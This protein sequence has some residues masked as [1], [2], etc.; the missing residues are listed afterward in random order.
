VVLVLFG[1]T[2]SYGQWRLSQNFTTGSPI[3]V[4]AVQ[5]AIRREFR[6]RPEYQQLGIAEYIALTQKAAAARPDLVFWP[7]Y[8]ISFYLEEASPE[9]AM[10]MRASHRLG[11]DLILGGP[12]YAFAGDATVYHNSIYLLRDARIAGRYDKMRLLPVAEDDVLGSFAG[13]DSYAPG[14]GAD[15]LRAGPASVGAFLCFEAMYPEV[16]RR[17]TAAGADVLANL[18]NDD[19]FGSVSAARHHLAMA[20]VRAIENRRYLIRVTSSGFSA[21]I[22]PYGRAN[23]VS[24]FGVPDVLTTEIYRSTAQTFYQLWGDLVAWLA[25]GTV[26]LASLIRRQTAILP[27]QAMEVG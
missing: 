9:R 15:L 12:H 17:F 25:V 13:G 26:L 6:W 5:G 18:S 2:W 20:S 3:T 11:A 8:A 10:L 4:A 19:W 27:P 7:E 16:V 1:A 14:S 22:D 23:A 21:I 24:A